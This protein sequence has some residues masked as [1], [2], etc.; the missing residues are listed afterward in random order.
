VRVV[1]HPPS[2]RMILRW[3]QYLCLIAGVGAF[4]YCL[5]VIGSGWVYQTKQSN[6]F[7][8][9]IQ[10]DQSGR[11]KAAPGVGAVIGRLQIPRL[12]MTVMVVEGVD[13]NELSRAAGHI[14]GTT[15]PD[16][17]GNVGIAAHRDTFFRPLRNIR[18][19]D[20]IQLATLHGNYN[21]RVISTSVV[22]PS[23]VQVLAP[24]NRD[25]LTLVTYYPFYFVGAAPKRFIVRAMRALGKTNQGTTNQLKKEKVR[26]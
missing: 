16:R 17:H 24:T 11:V 20:T 10:K 13:E 4:S 15:L 25:T 8:L 12:G 19:N 6:S 1:L 18:R 9:A 22:E 3:T 14:P 21:Y 26:S 23:D 5:F 7:D 2:T